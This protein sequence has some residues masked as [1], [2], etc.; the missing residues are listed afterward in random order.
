MLVLVQAVILGITGLISLLAI[1]VVG[2]LAT[3]AK[4]WDIEGAGLVT[5]VIVYSVGAPAAGLT[6]AMGLWSMR[7]WARKAALLFEGVQI[8]VIVLGWLLALSSSDHNGF[9]WAWLPVSSL[10]VIV[11]ALLLTHPA[12]QVFG[13]PATT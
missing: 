3:G 13:R 10:P 5:V 9:N 6:I 1:T 11:G 7:R 12:R 2:L 8:L 4:T